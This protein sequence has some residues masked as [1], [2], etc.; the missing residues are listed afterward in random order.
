MKDNPLNLWDTIKQTG[1]IAIQRNITGAQW[2]VVRYGDGWTQK[3][4][5]NSFANACKH[6]L[7]LTENHHD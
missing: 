2:Q 1:N 6:Y 7:E 5:Y 4:V 3:Y